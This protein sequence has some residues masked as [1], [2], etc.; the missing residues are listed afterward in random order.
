MFTQAQIKLVLLAIWEL[1][2]E[3]IPRLSIYPLLDPKCPLFGTKKT[4][5]GGTR[6]VL[7]VIVQRAAVAG[8]LVLGLGLL[9]LKPKTLKP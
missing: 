5:F 6:R 2:L 4:L 7:V 3:I 1:N 8:G 9:N